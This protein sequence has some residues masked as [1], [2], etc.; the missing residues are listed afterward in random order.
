[1]TTIRSVIPTLRITRI[2]ASLPLYHALGFEIAWQ[3]QLG[4]DA[5]RLTC[6]AQDAKELFL[7]EHPVAPFG[8]VVHVMVTGLDGIVARAREAG[9][10]PTFGPERRAWGDR[11]AYYTDADGNV[12]RFGETV[13]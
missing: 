10:E 3:H 1:M 5:P 9:F 6:V 2:E 7:T 13:G 11:E 4:P 12:L 8:A